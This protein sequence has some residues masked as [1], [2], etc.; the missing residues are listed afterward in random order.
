MNK[1]S[2]NFVSYLIINNDEKVA[3]NE[4]R[5]TKTI[6]DPTGIASQ[7]TELK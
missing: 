1:V 3:K 6:S 5:Q 4:N 7:L 2:L